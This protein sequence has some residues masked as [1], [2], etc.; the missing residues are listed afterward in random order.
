MANSSFLVHAAMS[1]AA[2]GS[3]GSAQSPI[4]RQRQRQ[5]IS[6]G[7]T[8]QSNPYFTALRSLELVSIYLDGI[9][10]CQ[11]DAVAHNPGLRTAV[12][13]P[14]PG[15]V[16]RM[17]RSKYTEVVAEDRT[18]ERLVEGDPVLDF[19]AKGLEHDSR[20]M[21]IVGNK[22]VLVEEATISLLKPI[23]QIPVEQ[24]HKWYNARGHQ[25]VHEVDVVVN[26]FLIDRVT[27]A[28]PWDDAGPRDGKSIYLCAQVLEKFYVFGS[29][30]IGVAGH[31]AGTTISNFAWS[32]AE[33][34]PYRRAAS[35]F[36]R[37]PFNLVPTRQSTGSALQ[38][39]E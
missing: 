38:S 33:S 26:A 39:V 24:R 5:E 34:V 9:G 11:E 22:L 32:P 31:I 7:P 25:V 8:I 3:H 21:C 27:S 1:S 15:S 13:D 36:S 6:L 12:T 14:A 17:A 28:A 16:T 30:V 35:I 18:T 10:M 20:V 4:Q 2:D 37:C 29:A 19:G 23:R